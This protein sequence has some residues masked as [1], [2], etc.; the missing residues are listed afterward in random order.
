[1]RSRKILLCGIVMIMLSGCAT[2]KTQHTL[3]RLQSQVSLMEERIAQLERLG[4]QRAL[5]PSAGEPQTFQATGAHA[6]ERSPA[7]KPVEPSGP[8][9]APSVKPTTREIQQA[10]KA[11]GFYQGSADGKMGALTRDAIRAFQQAHD[12]KVDGIVGT[13]TWSKLSA[14]TDLS[15]AGDELGAAEVLK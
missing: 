13:K 6:A 5:Q 15:A 2:P 8:S 10:L 4:T 9:A 1:M 7:V 3:M 11:A 12:L 14:Y